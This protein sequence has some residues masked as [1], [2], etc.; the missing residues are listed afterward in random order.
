MRKVKKERRGRRKEYAAKFNC[1][2]YPDKRPWGIKAE[3]A[4]PSATQNEINEKE[5]ET[6]LKNGVR[7]VAEG[8][9]MP[10]EYEAVKLFRKAKILYGPSKAANAGEIG[11]AH[12]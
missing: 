12:V 3:V 8:A 5:A 7:V 9:N 1:D 10:T 4:F 2:Y 11:R 6:M